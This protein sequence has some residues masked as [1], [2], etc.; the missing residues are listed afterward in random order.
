MGGYYFPNLA[1]FKYTRIPQIESWH[2]SKRELRAFRTLAI[3]WHHGC[4]RSTDN[5]CPTWNM[6]KCGARRSVLV[7]IGVALVIGDDDTLSP[8]QEESLA[9]AG[10][11][12]SHADDV[13]P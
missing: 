8:D 10:I 11:A 6:N 9:G 5:T 3:G 1:H 12:L 4:S 13:P 2:A 7:S